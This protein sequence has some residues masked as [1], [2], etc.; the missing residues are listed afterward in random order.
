M[1]K[2]I[3][4]LFVLAFY[5]CEN[6]H[7]KKQVNVLAG[8]GKGLPP[9]KKDTIKYKTIPV[10][11]DTIP[12]KDP[13][14]TRFAILVNSG[15]EHKHSLDLCLRGIECLKPGCEYLEKLIY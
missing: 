8:L 1:K 10:L 12:F 15:K 14:K 3:L 6:K 5:L 2:I 11:Q 7:N 9:A 13:V 4:F